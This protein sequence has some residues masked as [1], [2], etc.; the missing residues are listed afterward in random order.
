M[1]RENTHISNQMSHDVFEREYIHVLGEHEKD[2]DGGTTD[3]D[4]EL[5]NLM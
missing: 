3:H 2:M 5:E 1:L 4:I